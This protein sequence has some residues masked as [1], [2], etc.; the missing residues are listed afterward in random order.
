MVSVFIWFGDFGL[1][2]C[3]GCGEFTCDMILQKFCPLF[4]IGLVGRRVEGGVRL[5]LNKCSSLFLS[6]SDSTALILNYCLY[7][8]GK[9]PKQLIFSNH[10]EK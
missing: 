3:D 5:K 8:F 10:Y 7:N 1:Y 9:I 2:P 6:Y 4:G